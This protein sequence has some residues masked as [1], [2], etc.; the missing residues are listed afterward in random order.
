MPKIDE[1]NK[2]NQSD[3]TRCESI[4]LNTHPDTV[5][6]WRGKCWIAECDIN[7]VRR[8]VCQGTWK[9]I[10]GKTRYCRTSNPAHTCTRTL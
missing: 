7:A 9:T 6:K 3:D 8:C 5:E 1:L 10:Y 2:V 4:K